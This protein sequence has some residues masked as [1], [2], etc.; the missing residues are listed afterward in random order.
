MTLELV[1]EF[2]LS[3]A[4]R[5]AIRDL[6]CEA[7]PDAGFSATKIY[8]KQIPPRR[9]LATRGGR[10]VGHLGLEH[11]VIGTVSGPASLFGIVDLC[12]R[13]S[14]RG[15]G[16]ASRMLAWVD[17]LARRHNVDFL[18]L[19][20]HDP[21]LYERNGFARAGNVLRWTKVHEHRTLGIGEEPLEELMVKPAGA[22]AWPDGP[23]DLLG[24]QF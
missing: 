1:D 24:Y 17:A 14:C 15:Q 10:L 2:R 23:V 20:A 3:A 21:R 7:F 5:E 16:V 19:F 13:A 18:M 11:R 12:V 22:R 9:L 4:Q 6:L 8:Y